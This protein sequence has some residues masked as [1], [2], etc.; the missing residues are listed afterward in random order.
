MRVKG[1]WGRERRGGDGGSHLR[2]TFPLLIQSREG[3]VHLVVVKGSF[4]GGLV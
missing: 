2:V 4:V 3:R 1:N